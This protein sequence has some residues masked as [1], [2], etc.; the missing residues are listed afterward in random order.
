MSDLRIGI[1]SCLLG[2]NV[3]Y[4][5][6]HKRDAFIVDTLGPFVSFVPVCPEL[7]VGMGAPRESLRLVRG[8]ADDAAPRL[9][10]PKSGRDWTAEMTRYAARRTRELEAL[11]LSGYILKKDSPTCGM[12]RVRVYDGN[13][14]PAKSGRGVFAEALLARMP[15]LPVEEEGRLGDP[16]LREN[17]VERVFAYR[18][19]RGFLDAR[20]TQGDLVRFHSGEKLLLLAHEPAAYTA[21]GRLVAGA[22]ALPRAEL[23]ERY[24]A[25]YMSALAKLATV[26][27]HVNVLQHMAG[28]FK[29]LLD[30][31]DRREVAASIE[32]YGARLV[33]LV[34]PL[35]LIRHHVRRHEIAYLAGQAYLE[36]HPRELMLR[37]HA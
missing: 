37:N 31:G 18:R 24:F 35:T 12:Q 34:V 36:P 6:G 19:V 23:R 9:I 32:A 15:F 5:G 17:F 14:V 22:K 16:H 20:F 27:R 11:D 28:Y 29:T 25:A 4:D 26:R 8:S 3:R 30:E 13:G 2:E 1:S 10:A 33:P 21:L 7:D